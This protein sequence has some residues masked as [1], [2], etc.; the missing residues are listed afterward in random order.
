MFLNLPSSH[1][2]NFSYMHN[3][4]QTPNEKK[5][6]LSP[7]FF[8]SFFTLHLLLFSSFFSWTTSRAWLLFYI[9][10]IKFSFFFSKKSSINIIIFIIFYIYFS[11]VSLTCIF[12][13]SSSLSSLLHIYTTHL[14][15][16]T[17][18]KDIALFF[19]SIKKKKW[20]MFITA[21]VILCVKNSSQSREKPTHV[22]VCVTSLFYI[23]H[24]WPINEIIK[25]IID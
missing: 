16:C 14:I 12:Y 20:D 17:Q 10:S 3:N 23:F 1:L 18:Q 24:K 25:L 9:N 21:E 4:T 15:H 2:R 7:L 22:C 11:D 5:C 13:L 6:F 8:F 19:Q